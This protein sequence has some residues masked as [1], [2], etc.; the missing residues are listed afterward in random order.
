M[1]IEYLFQGERP[2]RM[3]LAR[4]P[5][6]LGKVTKVGGSHAAMLAMAFWT[7]FTFVAYFT[8]TPQ[9]FLDFFT[10]QANFHSLP[11]YSG[12]Y[13]Q[14]LRRRRAGSRADMHSH[15]PPMPVSRA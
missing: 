5:W 11:D 8:Y 14:Y 10:W 1:Y 4:Q 9:F 2:A 12:D 13:A 6:S 7:G 3:R 15:L